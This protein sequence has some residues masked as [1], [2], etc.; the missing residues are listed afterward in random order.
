[1]IHSNLAA[2]QPT[3]GGECRDRLFQLEM[4]RGK[5]TH[6]KETSGMSSLTD[7]II[8]IPHAFSHTQE[9]A[10]GEGV[11]A[12][13][14]VLLKDLLKLLGDKPSIANRHQER[15]VLFF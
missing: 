3:K 13:V 5:K 15:Q 12:L 8:E 6:Q 7:R 10:K 14:V 2:V 4:S 11:L 1:V 9:F